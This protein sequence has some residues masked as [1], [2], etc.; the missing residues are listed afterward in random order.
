MVANHR[1]DKRKLEEERTTE[2]EEFGRPCKRMRYS[3]LGHSNFLGSHNTVRAQ[4]DQKMEELGSPEFHLSKRRC[5]AQVLSNSGTLTTKDKDECS[6][7][8]LP[9][10]KDV[11]DSSDDCIGDTSIVSDDEGPTAK[12]VRF[13]DKH[14][15]LAIPNR[16]TYT[17]EFKRAT[18]YTRRETKAFITTYRELMI[19]IR[20][21]TGCQCVRIKCCPMC[22]LILNERDE[23]S[24]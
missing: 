3:P 16:E 18:W 14:R 21:K 12:R 13:A 4:Q 6:P 11:S 1:L 2:A 5:L 8:T 22:K 10:E 23:H 24:G 17:K 19:T 7:S 20:A 15:I 9:K